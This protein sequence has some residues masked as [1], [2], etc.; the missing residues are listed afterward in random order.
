VEKQAIPERIDRKR[1]RS[2]AAFCGARA[3]AAPGASR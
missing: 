2:Q 3:D 1:G